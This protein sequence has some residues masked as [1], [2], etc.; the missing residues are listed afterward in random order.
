MA[1]CKSYVG[2]EGTK[3]KVTL[4]DCDGEVIDVSTASVKQI[5]FVK[6]KAS[7]PSTK[8]EVVKTLLFE[9]DGSDGVMYYI[10]EPGFL[11]VKGSYAGQP[12]VELP[13]GKW[14]GTPI[15]F[16]VAETVSA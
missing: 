6:P 15:K 10:I 8:E 16:S 3:V 4:K 1:S 2:N 5:T 12:Y 9:T 7:D 14:Y 13:T 11:D